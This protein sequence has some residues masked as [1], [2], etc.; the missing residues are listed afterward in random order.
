MQL[1]MRWGPSIN[2]VITF[3]GG[4]GCQMMMVDDGRGGGGREVMTSSSIY[5]ENANANAN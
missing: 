1:D 4:G 2:F 3:E 5:F